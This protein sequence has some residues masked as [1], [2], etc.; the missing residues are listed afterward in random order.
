MT[1]KQFSVARGIS[2]R[3]AYRLVEQGKLTVKKELI[4][5]PST[6]KMWVLVVV[7]KD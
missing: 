7:D 6:R 1:L 5:V 2:L 3:D 4:S